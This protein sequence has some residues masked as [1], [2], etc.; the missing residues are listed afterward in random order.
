[1]DLVDAGE[2]LGAQRVAGL[3]EGDDAPLV[4]GQGPPR[5]HAG[6]HALERGVEVLLGDLHAARPGGEDGRLVAHVGQVGAGEA[7]GLAGDDVEVD[8]LA[9]RLVARVDLEDLLAA[10]DAGRRDE[11]LAVEAPRP[12]QRGVELVEQVGGGHDHDAVGRAHPVHLDEQLVERLLAL[13]VVVRAAFTA[14]RVDLVDE[15]D[16]RRVLARLAEQAPDARGAE[17][18][19]HL[20]EARGR[21]RVEVRPRLLG[22]RLC[23]QGLA[24]ARRAVQEDA[25]G[26]LGAERREARRVAQELHD[27][28]ELG[29]GLVRPG[30]VLPSHPA[31][32][33]RLD[34]LRLRARHQ[35]HHPPQEEDQQRHEDDREPREDPRLDALP[36]VPVGGIELYGWRRDR[37]EEVH[38]C[39]GPSEPAS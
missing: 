30:H 29:L 26:D 8:V 37:D 6:D 9:Q 35:L 20:H 16:G 38:P 13:G 25:G 23:Q 7:G 22:D 32:R 5:L 18:R 12:Q 39:S 24:G 17:A 31:L 1:V 21:L 36:V 19:E 4:V 2:Q 28:L 34:L 10:A 33:R 27:L 14:D 3:V 11:D 15:D